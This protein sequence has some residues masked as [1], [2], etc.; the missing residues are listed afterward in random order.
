MKITNVE[1]GKE[2]LYIQR[3]DLMN[4]TD[5]TFVPQSIYD[6]YKF[7]LIDKDLKDFIEFSD[8]KEI[9]YLNS[10][11]FI[12]DYRVYQ[13]KTIE[14]L[15]ELGKHYEKK[16]NDMAITYNNMSNKKRKDNYLLK[17]E[18]D[19]LTYKFY[20]IIY[21]LKV[22]KGITTIPLP[23]VVDDKGFSYEENNHIYVLRE[24]LNK[25]YFIIERKDYKGIKPDENIPIDFLNKSFKIV[26]S[27]L[28]DTNNFSIERKYIPQKRHILII[29]KKYKEKEIETKTELIP[30]KGRKKILKPNKKD[31]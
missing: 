11:D 9:D 7:S 3:E 26:I 5:S 24:S 20:S 1:F 27:L 28:N 4:L 30:L 2:K 25:N 22:K 10:F 31:A 19:H 14:E 23:I 13:E 17:K 12:L 16:L 18:H 21:M 8:P 29:V 6:K 15:T